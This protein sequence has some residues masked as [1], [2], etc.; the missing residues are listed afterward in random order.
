MLDTRLSAAIADVFGLDPVEVTA[1]SSA[2]TIPDWD[3][4]GHFRLILHL[5]EV[6]EIRFPG[7]EIPELN[8]AGKLQEA[9]T[10]L[11]ALK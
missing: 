8:T 11:N 10:R 4:T 6:F 3:S 9:L 7:N 2:D 1:E 5:E